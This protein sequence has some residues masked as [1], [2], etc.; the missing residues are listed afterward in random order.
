MDRTL[1]GDFHEFGA[2][3]IGQRARQLNVEL[4]PIDPTL[5]RLAFLAIDRV[6]F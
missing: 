1:A 4:D 5:F 2:L 6:D 3:L